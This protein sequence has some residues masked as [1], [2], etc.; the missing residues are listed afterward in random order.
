VALDA[1]LQRQRAAHPD[2]YQDLSLTVVKLLGSGEYVA[3]RPGATAPG[4]FGLAVKDYAHSTA[5]NR[6]YGDLITQRL[7][8]AALAGSPP[9]LAYGQLD[10]IATH[11]TQQEDAANKVERQVAKSAAALLLQ[12]HV[13]QV[14]DAI[15]TGASNKGTWVRLRERPIE[16]RVVSGFEGA[17]VG[18]RVRV[19]LVSTNVERGFIDFA[20][21]R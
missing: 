9:P 12:S 18:D 17:D 20:R 4:H 19:R 13:G 16:G 2:T 1:F 15:V 11:L 7:I 21:V 8:K 14:F 3:E 5:P 10:A 6:R